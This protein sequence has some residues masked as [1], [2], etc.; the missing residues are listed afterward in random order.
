MVVAGNAHKA[1]QVLQESLQLA[2]D[3]GYHDILPHI[4]VNLGGAAYALGR[5]QKARE[6]YLDALERKQRD[7]RVFQADVHCWLG[8]VE[9]SAANHRAA[10][11]HLHRALQLAWHLQYLEIVCESL[12]NLSELHLSLGHA[13][14]AAQLTYIVQKRPGLSHSL[15]ERVHD[16]VAQLESTRS[17][18][19][20]KNLLEQNQKRQLEQVVATVLETATPYAEHGSGSSAN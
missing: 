20:F 6:L 10:Y 14:E 4:L 18:D 2:K 16:L 5:Y 7:D 3:I 8:R 9:T 17:P 11:H 1:E 12:V 19:T 15:K 13:E